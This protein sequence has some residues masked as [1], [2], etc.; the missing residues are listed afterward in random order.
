MLTELESYE[1]WLRLL[2]GGETTIIWSLSTRDLTC[3]NITVIGKK[4][5]NINECQYARVLPA[6]WGVWRAVRGENTSG[7]DHRNRHIT[8][9]AIELQ[10]LD[11]FLSWGWWRDKFSNLNYLHDVR[12]MAHGV[13]YIMQAPA[14][15]K[16][17]LGFAKGLLKMT[18]SKFF[19]K[20][21]PPPPS[22]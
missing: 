19:P 4:I 3:Q 21:D 16:T 1:H 15:P 14:L 10:R 6:W 7:W 2:K 17:L 22:S 20:I 11:H 8:K 12:E 5:M 13:F 9:E 18:S